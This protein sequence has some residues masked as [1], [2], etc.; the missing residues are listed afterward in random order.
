MR[1]LPSNEL[2]SLIGFL[3]V[4]LLF[5][6]VDVRN[7]GWDDEDPWHFRL[8]EWTSRL[9]GLS[10]ALALAFGWIDL[11]IPDEL[12]LIPVALVAVPGSVAV[13]CAILL[14]VE[15]LFRDRGPDPGAI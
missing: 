15:M 14:G 6:S 11:F 2:V 5:F 13:A 8:F 3:A 4:L 10:T 1:N 7:R 12:G 9:G